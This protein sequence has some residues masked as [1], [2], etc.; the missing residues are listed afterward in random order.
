MTVAASTQDRSFEGAAVAGGVTYTGVTLTGG[1]GPAGLVD[2]AKLGDPLCHVGSLASATGKIVLCRRG[3]NARVEKSLAV[4]QAGGVGMILYNVNDTQSLNTDNH[5]LPSVHVNFTK[6]S[7]I[8]A[9]IASAGAGATGSIVGGK[10][11]YGGGN[12][13]ADFSSRGPSIGGG[14]DIVKPDVTAPGVNILAGNTPT[15]FLGAPGQLFQ[16]ISGTSMSSPHVAGLAA[17]LIQK[18]PAWTPAAIKSA[19]MTSAR[20]NL[21][22]EDGSTPADPFDFGAGH[23]AP[24]SAASPGLV[25]DLGFND[26]R[27]FLRSQGLCT[28][29]FGTTPAPVMKPTDL[30]LPSFGIGKLAGTLTVSRAVTNVGPA[31]TYTVSVS[32]P[33]GIKVEVTPSTLTLASGA[34]GT[35]SVKFTTLAGATF[36]EYTFGSLTWSNGSTAARSPIA[37]R[38]VP[39]A[40]PS[41]ITGTGVSGSKTYSVTFG[42][43]GPFSATPQGLQAAHTDT[44]T[45]ADDPTNDFNTD[46]PAGNQGIQVHK[47]TIPAG[48]PLARFQTF[49]TVNPNDDLDLY[50]YS[51]SDD[52]KTRTLVGFSAGGTA[53]EVVTVNKPSG[54]YEVYVHGWEVVPGVS[55]T[56]YDWILASTAA[57]NMTVTA[58]TSATTGA[59]ADVTANWSGLTAGTK[60]LGRISYSNGTSEIGGTIVRVDS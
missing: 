51:V 32:A 29:C 22:K 38:P 7:A 37:V 14:G 16:S 23:V 56:L 30:N 50:V 44:R 4:K 43:T 6:G 42:Y 58:P 18:Y 52:E 48:T 17:L 53:S 11:V 57:G 39:L 59:T 9:Y 1:V 2:A 19:L 15:A 49:G 20:Q 47:F 28:L 13:M 10:A 34:T 21:T 54:K 8:K 25:Y 35:Y 3:D 26:Y 12:T 55:Y 33:A 46:D 40:A 27:G 31:G 24:N 60:Y 41:E 36:N 5:Y 45:L